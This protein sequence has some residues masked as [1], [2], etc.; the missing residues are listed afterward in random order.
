MAY[1]ESDPEREHEMHFVSD[2]TH[3]SGTG[4]ADVK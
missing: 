4:C 3:R 1:N 2:Q